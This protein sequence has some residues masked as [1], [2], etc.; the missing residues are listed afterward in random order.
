M[1]AKASAKYIQANQERRKGKAKQQKFTLSERD[2]FLIVSMKY[3][4]ATLP[5]PQR[6]VLK[7]LKQLLPYRTLSER[8]LRRIAEKALSD[9]R[10][11][12]FWEAHLVPP[13]DREMGK[14]IQSLLPGVR[15]VFVI[16][17][18]CHI[19]PKMVSWYLGLSAARIFEHFFVGGQAIGLGAGKAVQALAASLNLVSEIVENLN[20]FA[21]VYRDS[22]EGE[23]GA[24]PLMEV[25][26]RCTLVSRSPS[27]RG[28]IAPSELKPESLHWAFVCIEAM[29]GKNNNG[30]VARILDFPLTPS[31]LLPIDWSPN[32]DGA[33]VHLSFLQRMVQQGRGVVAMAGGEG[34]GE[35]VLAAYQAKKSGGLLFNF[36]VIDDACAEQILR[37]RGYRLSDIPNRHEWWEKKNRFL[38]AH[39]RYA[40]E[41]PFRTFREIANRLRLSVKQVK[42]LLEDAVRK[43]EDDKPILTLKVQPPSLEMELEME[44]MKRWGLAE[45]RVVPSFNSR[46]GFKALGQTAV[47]LL[48]SMIG[49]KKEFT[50]GLGGGSA[51]RT[52]VEA[53]NLKRV[54]KNFPELSRLS[55]CALA[56][57]PLPTVLS[58]TP[59]TLVAPIV[60]RYSDQPGVEVC[61][62]ETRKAEKLDA[63]FVGIGS[64]VP[65][66]N[67]SYFLESEPNIK[68]V[69][70]RLAGLLLFQFITRDGEILPTQWMDKL[71][72]MPLT[73]LKNMVNQRKP[74]V[75]VAYGPHK[76]TAI[77]AAYKAGLFNCLVIDCALAERLLELS[78]NEMALI[79]HNHGDGEDG[80]ER[81][82]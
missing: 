72:A 82:E 62:Y 27:V 78:K 28:T 81:H 68:D 67:L 75:I 33:C 10:S 73:E 35:A 40:M 39:L 80:R 57:N 79:W 26:S 13:I 42:R 69:S 54:F 47:N 50:V 71:K 16:P 64:M 53:L 23:T 4:T 63:V 8:Q 48:V 76:A 25:I 46:E 61:Y 18:V 11:E 70:E 12:Q 52:V 41:P 6:E 74:V 56:R 9:P 38:V 65:P 3:A 19:D 37:L 5:L 17:S 29:N 21:L 22:L 66:D 59:Q 60:S 58:V 45:V 31:G 2:I 15:E 1:R 32:P 43:H 7:R 36:L 24:E 30:V 34:S 14:A 55:I 44:L 20:F 51:I 49:S 77:L